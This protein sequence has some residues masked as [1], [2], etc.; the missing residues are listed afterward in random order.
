[1]VRFLLPDLGRLSL[2][3]CPTGTTAARDAVV[4]DNDLMVLILTALNNGARDD[5]CKLVRRWCAT[6]KGACND[7]TWRFLID[8]LFGVVVQGNPGGFRKNTSYRDRPRAL[9]LWMCRRWD[10]GRLEKYLHAEAAWRALGDRVTVRY[11]DADGRVLHDREHEQA[12]LDFLKARHRLNLEDDDDLDYDTYNATISYMHYRVW[13]FCSWALQYRHDA[14]RW[15]LNAGLLRLD[16]DLCSPNQHGDER[17]VR[18]GRPFRWF[19]PYRLLGLAILNTES[20]EIDAIRF[21]LSLGVDPNNLG[22]EASD[23][24]QGNELVPKAQRRYADEEGAEQLAFYHITHHLHEVFKRTNGYADESDMHGQRHI[25]YLTAQEIYEELWNWGGEMYKASL[26]YR[27]YYRNTKNRALLRYAEMLMGLCKSTYKTQ[28]VSR[29]QAEQWYQVALQRMY[30]RFPY[31]TGLR[32]EDGAP[33]G[34]EN[35]GTGTFWSG[36]AEWEDLWKLDEHGRTKLMGTAPPAPT[37][38]RTPLPE[39]ADAFLRDDLGDDF[40]EQLQG[41]S[42]G[43]GDGDDDANPAMDGGDEEDD[44]ERS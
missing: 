37:P 11:G 18:F 12:I 6:H 25:N 1:M 17:D 28:T 16:K 14:L 32:F 31:I 5:A 4:T 35:L 7:D 15:V 36:Q 13:Y 42:D 24:V 9:L 20:D 10:R 23:L 43:F 34:H 41:G 39:D 3:P 19:E 29:K 21:V 27:A 44:D 26:M 38:P 33:V 40:W 2:R 8:R 30:A 22:I